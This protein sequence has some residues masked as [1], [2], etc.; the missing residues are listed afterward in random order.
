MTYNPSFQESQGPILEYAVQGQLTFLA[1]S[2][3]VKGNCVY[4]SG[5]DQVSTTTAE[6]PAAIGVVTSVKP[7]TVTGG[8]IVTVMMFKYK[9][10]V[11]M[12]ASGTINPGDQVVSA[13]SGAVITMAPASTATSTDI[14]NARSI[15]GLAF[16]GATNGNL[17]GI[18][19]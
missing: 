3:V 11:L 4:L 16:Y 10:K 9:A 5:N 19:V 7:G 13:S 17:A 12:T 18:L 14:N 2:E 1:T 15:V 8:L 6:S